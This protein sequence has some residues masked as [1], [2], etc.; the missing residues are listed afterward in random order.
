MHPLQRQPESWGCSA[1]RRLWGD[2]RVAFQFLK[3]GSKKERD[4]FFSRVC[5]DGTMG[6]SFKLKEGRY[7]LDIRKKFVTIRV[8]RQWHRLPREAVDAPH[9]WGHSR[10]GWTVL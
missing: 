10:S 5:C 2:L 3:G 7:R 1:W 4:R 8:V 9:P 6:N